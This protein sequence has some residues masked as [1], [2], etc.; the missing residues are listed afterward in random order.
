[1]IVGHEVFTVAYM[2][3][4]GVENGELLAL[5][6]AHGFDAL[7][8]KDTGMLYEQNLASIPCSIVVLQAPSNELDDIAP[9]VPCLLQQLNSLVPKS[10][11][12]IG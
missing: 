3:W 8:T 9:L 6:A 12:R 5:A 2:K 11:L 7:L 4:N 1:M 10:I